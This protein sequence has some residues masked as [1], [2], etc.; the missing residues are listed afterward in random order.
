MRSIVERQDDAIDIEA[1]GNPQGTAQRRH[2][3]RHPRPEPQRS[4]A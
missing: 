1:P 2:V 3:R 4:G